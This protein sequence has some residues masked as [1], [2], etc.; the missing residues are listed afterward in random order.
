MWAQD[1]SEAAT[2]V[3]GNGSLMEKSYPGK[4]PCHCRW[5]TR[6]HIV[7]AARRVIG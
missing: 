7:Y 4:A 3:S 5:A 2:Q 1:F 6:L